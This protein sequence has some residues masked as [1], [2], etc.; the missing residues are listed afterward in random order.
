MNKVQEVVL[1]QSDDKYAPPD[2]PC[3]V[4]SVIGPDAFLKV[5]RYEE[6]NDTVTMTTIEQVAV[7]LRDLM[8]ALH[9]GAP[10]PAWFGIHDVRAAGVPVEDKP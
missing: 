7:P 3:L 10:D 4:V 6:T 8:M 5:V 1:S 9:I 2:M